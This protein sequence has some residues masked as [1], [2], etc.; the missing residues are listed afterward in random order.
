MTDVNGLERIDQL[1]FAGEYFEAV[2]EIRRYF[3]YG[4]AQGIETRLRFAGELGLSRPSH[5][6]YG[7]QWEEGR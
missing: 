6:K 2:A 7:L 5:S 3:D 1:I 4:I